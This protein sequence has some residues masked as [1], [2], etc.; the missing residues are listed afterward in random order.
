MLWTSRCHWSW[1]SW[2]S[3]NTLDSHSWGTRFESRPLLDILSEIFTVFLSLFI[4]CGD[5]K[6]YHYIGHDVIVWT[7]YVCQFLFS[8]IWILDTL[9]KAEA[10][11]R[12]LRLTW[13]WYTFFL[14]RMKHCE[15]Y[16]AYCESLCVIPKFPFLLLFTYFHL[17]KLS[18]LFT[19]SDRQGKEWRFL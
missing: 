6:A 7:E 14:H 8:G 16:C 10:K 9:R 13:I 18:R 11:D 15:L 12:V 2:C 19:K 17:R 3:G 1:S 4:E 5:S